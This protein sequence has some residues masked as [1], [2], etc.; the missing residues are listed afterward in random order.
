MKNIFRFAGP[1]AGLALAYPV[2]FMV[3]GYPL[4]L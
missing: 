3:K 1:L 4:G 2:R